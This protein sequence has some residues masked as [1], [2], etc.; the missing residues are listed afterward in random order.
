MGVLR[1]NDI[2]KCIDGLPGYNKH[3]VSQFEDY[4][5]FYR[6]WKV[7]GSDA[8]VTYRFMY[9]GNVT[10]TADNQTTTVHRFH[11]G[12]TP[13]IL[14]WATQKLADK[15][16][17]GQDEL[18]IPA[19]YEEMIELGPKMHQM[20]TRVAKPDSIGRAYT[21][22]KKYS[23]A[24]HKKVAARFKDK[25]SDANDYGG[26]FPTN[27]QP[28]R[29]V[30]PQQ[31]VPADAMDEDIQAHHYTAPNIISRTHFGAMCMMNTPENGLTIDNDKHAIRIPP[32]MI[33]I[34]IDYLVKVSG[35]KL[36]GMPNN[37]AYA[38]RYPQINTQG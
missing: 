29:P 24:V 38:S 37:E 20:T 12:R 21:V 27:R 13:P 28:V 33:T 3:S 8:K 30:V 5:K 7:I 11:E 36:L 6:E 18:S 22:G 23:L 34:K 4:G 2:A 25:T 31:G 17:D 9:Q 16:H 15:D 19:S 35:R 1:L 32:C 14:L 10:E 26:T